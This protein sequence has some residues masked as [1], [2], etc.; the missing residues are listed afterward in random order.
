MLRWSG[1]LRIELPSR[2]SLKGGKGF[3]EIPIT[4]H[5]A[6]STRTSPD[7]MRRATQYRKPK[8]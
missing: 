1:S 8:F 7:F 3:C 4:L 5:R 2:S 6:R